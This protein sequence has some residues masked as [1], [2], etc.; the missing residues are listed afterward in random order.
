MNPSLGHSLPRFS[1]KEVKMMTSK[2]SCGFDVCYVSSVVV[3]P[4]SRFQN[5]GDGCESINVLSQH[6]LTWILKGRIQLKLTLTKIKNR[7]G[8]M[9]FKLKCI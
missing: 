7:K 3:R 8:E 5:G 2:L 4:L 1:N 6:L 9:Y